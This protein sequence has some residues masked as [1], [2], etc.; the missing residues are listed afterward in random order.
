MHGQLM[1]ELMLNSNLLMESLMQLTI[2]SFLVT[3]F[4]QAECELPLLRDA[5]LHRE[6]LESSYLCCKAI[7]LNTHGQMYN[8]CVRGAMLYSSEC[9]DLRK[10]DKKRLEGSERAML[11][12]LCNIT[13]KQCVSTN[14]LLSRLKLKSLDSV[15][16]CNRLRRLGHVK[17]RELYTGQILSLELEVKRSR[18][19]LKKYWLGAIKDDLKQ[20]NLQAETFQN[21]SEQRN[22]LKTA[23]HTL[24]GFVT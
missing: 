16:R 13:K 9:W 10:E 17:R 12:W 19:C 5:A 8:S 2:L 15:L 20:Q 1:Q 11:L 14:S 3:A 18:G 22:R 4:V 23:S 21:R 6:N 24:A 7:S